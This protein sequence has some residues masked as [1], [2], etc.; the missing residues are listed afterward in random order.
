[1]YTQH[2]AI[3]RN[4]VIQCVWV[5]EHA[6]DWDGLRRFHSNLSLGLLGRRV[7]LSPLPFARHRWVADGG[8]TDIDIDQSAR[9]RAEVSDW[10][11]RRSQLPIDPARGPVW[12]LGVLPLDDGSTAVTL[13]LSHYLIDG[14]GLVLTLRDAAVGT[15]RELCYPPPHSRPR[16]Q[17]VIQDAQLTAREAP[18]VFRALAAVARQARSQRLSTASAPAYRSVPVEDGEAEERIVI[19]GITICIDLA[20]WDA[21]AKALGGTSNTLGAG[22]AAKLGELIGRRRAGDGA[23]TLELPMDER[24]EGDTRA[25]AM[26]FVRVSLDPTLVTEDLREARSAIKRVLTTRRQTADSAPQVPWLTLIMPSWL[27][28]RMDKGAVADPDLPVFYSNLGDLG[29]LVSHVDGTPAEYFTARVI[30]Q[31]ETRRWIERIG[32]QLILQALRVPGRFVISVN[33]YQPGAENTKLALRRL[34]AQ[35][36]ADFKLSGEID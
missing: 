4:L 36:L 34:A 20:E 26:S 6:I 8:P 12:H 9:P 14:L 17:A 7:E 3:G 11:D 16:L 24:A 2:H 27:L 5:Y 29:S 30:A 25:N 31:R 33:A 28:R 19:P 21:R 35:A 23:V 15:T 32:G 22:F 10:A 13:V 18:E 1:L